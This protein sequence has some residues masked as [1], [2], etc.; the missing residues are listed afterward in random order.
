MER[1]YY[2]DNL[3]WLLILLL[4]PFHA[5]QIWSGGEYRGFYV[6]SHTNDILYVFSTAV[7]PWFMTFLFVLAGMSGRY[8]LQK[9]TERQFVAERIHKLLVPFIFGVFTLVPVMTYIAEIFFNGYSGTYLHQYVLF[10]T[11]QTDLTGYKGGFSPAHLWFL[12]YLFIIS[13]AALLVIKIQRKYLPQLRLQK[14]SYLNLIL[15]FVPEW[16]FLFILNIGGKSVGQFFLLYLLGYYILSQEKIL[17]TIERYRFIS[18]FLW[19]ISGSVYTYLYCFADISNALETGLFVFFGWMGI[20]SLLGVGQAS[21]NFHNKLSIYF[22]RA[23]FPLYIIH[24][25]VVVAA[26]F[27]ALKIS[28]GTA[29]QF[30]LIVSASFIVTLLLY[31]IIKRLPY[32][33]ALFGITKQKSV[34]C[35]K[36][37]KE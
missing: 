12:I 6:W 3:R 29:G 5:A 9:R 22:T 21:L 24:M 33:R 35:A 37:T 36:G 27:F 1:K 16:L 26:G 32:I 17:Q 30:V 20:V 25:P 28:A 2:I 31:E 4:F 7:Y 34:N 19:I 11:K 23:S 15:L 18:I 14:L 13:L 10:F 8:A